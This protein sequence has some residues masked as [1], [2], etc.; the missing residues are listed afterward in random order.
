VSHVTPLVFTP[1]THRQKLGLGGR[2]L[3]LVLSLGA[4]GMLVTAVFLHPAP[5]GVGTHRQIRLA[6]LNGQTPP[7]CELLRTT[8]IPCP[9]CG[10]TTSFAWF[11]RGNWLASVYVQPMGFLLALASGAMFW[12][13]LFMAV[14]GAPLHRLLQPIGGVSWIVGILGFAIAA[15]GWKIF[16]HLAHCD[17]WG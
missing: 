11:V 17:G 10:M 6:A 7:P 8:G 5:Q 1:P 14:S 3:A 13:G 9:T 4:L 2:L 16:I 12:A 15:W